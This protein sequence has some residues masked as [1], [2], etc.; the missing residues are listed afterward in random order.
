MFSS[1]FAVV[2][3]QGLTTFPYISLPPV[4]PLNLLLS[5]AKWIFPYS[6]LVKSLPNLVCATEEVIKPPRL[7]IQDPRNCYVLPCQPYQVL[8]FLPFH[9]LKP[10]QQTQRSIEQNRKPS[11]KPK[12]EPNCCLCFLELLFWSN[13]S[14]CWIP[15]APSPNSAALHP[16]LKCL[17]FHE[18]SKD[19]ATL[20]PNTTLNFSAGNILQSLSPHANVGLFIYFF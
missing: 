1:L 4:F 7:E 9:K 17:I 2:T 13:S 18:D 16:Q 20:P 8:V 19:Y 5:F 11:N 12:L 14:L 3:I 10:Q 15:P 6:I